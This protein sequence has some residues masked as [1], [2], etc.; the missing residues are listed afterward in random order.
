MLTE[1]ALWRCS[2]HVCLG[3]AL[4]LLPTVALAEFETPTAITD[5][6]IVVQPGMTVENG[7]IVMF[8]G[9]FVAVGTGVEIP[10]H[11]ELIDGSKLIA[12][13]GLID[14]HTFL[15]TPETTREPSDRQRIEDEHPDHSQKQLQA[16]R[17]ANRRG[18]RPHFRA[19]NLFAPDESTIKAHRAAGFTAALIAPRDGIFSGTSDFLSLSGLPIRRSILKSNVAMHGSFT[20]G[21]EGEYPRTLLGIFAQFRQVMLDADRHTSIERYAERHPG[22]TVRAP[23]DETLEALQ[24]LL[25]RSQ[26][27]IFEA[28]SENEIRRA[29]KLAAEF[30]LDVAISGGKEAW[31]VIDRIKRDN[32]PLIVSLN[33]DE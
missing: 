14:A 24:P 31:K 12:Y 30:N 32:I 25:S 15:G 10:P 1:S 20:I 2:R 3:L 29:L 5:V 27:L 6:T 11:A 21:E 9:R 19:L 7:T 13:P 22:G 18:I 17:F 26:R 16:T 4:S 23:T 33:F 8:E 28:N